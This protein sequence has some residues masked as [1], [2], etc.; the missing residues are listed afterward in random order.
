MENILQK[1]KLI[2]SFNKLQLIDKAADIITTLKDLIIQ[3]DLSVERKKLKEMEIKITQLNKN[4]KKNLKS[5]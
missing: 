3:L 5:I 4:I 1:K 2:T